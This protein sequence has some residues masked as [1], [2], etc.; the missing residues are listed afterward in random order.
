MPASLQFLLNPFFAQSWS[1]VEAAWRELFVA[2]ER[3]LGSSIPAVAKMYQYIDPLYQRVITHDVT[4]PLWPAEQQ[5]LKMVQTALIRQFVEGPD[6]KDIR[7][8]LSLQLV[9]VHTALGLRNDLEPYAPQELLSV[10]YGNATYYSDLTLVHTLRQALQGTRLQAVVAILLTQLT[11]AID[12]DTLISDWTGALL[13]AFILHVV[14]RYFPHLQPAD[15]DM[16]LANYFYDAIVCG[17]PVRE[18]MQVAIYAEGSKTAEAYEHFA[19][20]LFKNQEMIPV[21]TIA[22]ETRP[23]KSILVE[24]VGEVRG[25]LGKGFK[26]EE[27]IAT[28]YQN[29]V[30]RDIYMAWLRETLNV[31]ALVRRKELL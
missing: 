12:D 14:W 2:K 25:E 18:R 13:H 29:Q 15:Q 28:T 30:G 22:N 16:L 6:D 19:M 17:V 23:L 9:T 1:E 11:Q 7:D 4:D 26:L 27:F 3:L 20:A 8:A 24:F 31:A 10:F 5:M 21:D